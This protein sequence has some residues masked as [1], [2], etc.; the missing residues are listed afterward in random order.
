MAPM[1]NKTFINPET[2]EQVT[3]PMTAE[4]IAQRIKDENAPCVTRNTILARD[5]MAKL[6]DSLPLPTQAYLWTTRVAV[7]DAL[8]RW[9][10]DIAKQIVI[11]TKV[12]AELEATKQQILSLFP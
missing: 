7:E 5:A 2:G 8:D 11:N 6:M 4:E 3:V 12:T 1:Y 10:P 9:R